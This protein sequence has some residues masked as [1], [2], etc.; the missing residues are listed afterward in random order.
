[1]QFDEIKWFKSILEKCVELK[2]KLETTESHV[3][4]I[5]L[6]RELIHY[7]ERVAAEVVFWI[8]RII[9]SIE[10]IVGCLDWTTIC[11]T[12][13]SERMEGEIELDAVL[14]EAIPEKYR[15]YIKFYAPEVYVTW[16]KGVKIREIIDKIFSGTEPG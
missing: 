5:S 7:Y 12:S 13:K 11:L 14:N 10:Y 6:L 16:E 2:D 15:K 4:K 1:M 8:K 9:P 3:E